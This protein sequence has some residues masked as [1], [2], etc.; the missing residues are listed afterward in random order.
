MQ[1][2]FVQ[3][4]KEALRDMENIYNYIATVLMS[5]DTA[6]DQYDRITQGI[7]SLCQLPE[8]IKIMDSEPERSI[9][10]RRLLVDNYSIFYV[11]R[12]EKVIVTNVLY[13]ASDINR[14]L[15]RESEL[16]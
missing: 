4:T 7:M 11:I 9:K 6:M 8:R 5:P 10:M 15:S 1:E 3:M 13:S 12:D 14:R 2:Y 16:E